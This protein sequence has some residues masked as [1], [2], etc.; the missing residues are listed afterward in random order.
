MNCKEEI[1]THIVIAHHCAKYGDERLQ[2]AVVC[3]DSIAHHWTVVLV[4]CRQELLSPYVLADEVKDLRM[5]LIEWW[6]KQQ[7]AIGWPKPWENEM[8]NIDEIMANRI[9]SPAI[10]LNPPMAA[11]SYS[12]EKV[13]TILVRRIPVYHL[14]ERSGELRTPCEKQQKY[15]GAWEGKH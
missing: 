15:P 11:N 9:M 12:A 1:A 2:I 5:V 3:E 4:V 8:M 13:F 6:L 14:H 10:I 7:W